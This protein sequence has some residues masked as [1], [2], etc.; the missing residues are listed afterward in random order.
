MRKEFFRTEVFYPPNPTGTQ[1]YTLIVF[2]ARNE[3]KTHTTIW[4]DTSRDVPARLISIAKAVQEIASGQEYLAIVVVSK[5]AG[6]LDL[7]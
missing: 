1:D 3:G 5:I 4:T 2:T 7:Q 6:T